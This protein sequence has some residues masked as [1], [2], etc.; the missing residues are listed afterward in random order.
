MPEPVGYLYQCG[1]KPEL[2]ELRFDPHQRGLISVGYKPSP[3]IT[4][5]Q[6][7]AYA[8]AVREE[9]LEF[10]RQQIKDAYEQ[11][12]R[13]GFREGYYESIKDRAA[14]QP[15]TLEGWQLTPKEQL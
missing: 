7:E 6:A 11:G 15:T 13:D 9:A 2:T 14:R 8:Q 12:K 10:I 5:E 4:T 1:K 3:L